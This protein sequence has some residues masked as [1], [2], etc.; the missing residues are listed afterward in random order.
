MRYRQELFRIFRI[1]RASQTIVVT[2]NLREDHVV[3]VINGWIGGLFAPKH[4]DETVAT[5]V[6]DQSCALMLDVAGLEEVKA[7]RA[8]AEARLR[9]YQE[10]IGAT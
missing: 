5:L 8:D 7:R 3:E 9:R 1:N 10:A 2:V 4:L 6:G